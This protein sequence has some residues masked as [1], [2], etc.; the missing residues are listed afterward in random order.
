MTTIYFLGLGGLAC[1]ISRLYLRS[2]HK[3]ARSR[4][5]RYTVQ[6]VIDGERYSVTRLTEQQARAT[7]ELIHGIN[8][9]LPVSTGTERPGRIWNC[10]APLLLAIFATTASAQSFEYG[11]PVELAGVRRIA[12]HTEPPEERERIV[13]ELRRQLHH[14]QFTTPH[15]AEVLLTYTE[16]RFEIPQRKLIADDNT[17][18]IPVYRATVAGRGFIFKLG[19]SERPRLLTGF[20]SDRN[21]LW[22]RQPATRFARF[23]ID[24]YRKENK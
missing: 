8:P 11:S 2:R 22:G 24:I 6:A 23:F 5:R 3:L 16:R 14:L 17:T 10:I 19:V 1:A 15:D 13:R 12:V 21:W 18:S 7:M 9:Y 4:P 20:A